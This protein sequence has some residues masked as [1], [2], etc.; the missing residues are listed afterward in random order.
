[1]LTRRFFAYGAIAAPAIVAASSL[2]PIR[3]AKLILARELT[4]AEIVAL[5]DVRLDEGVGGWSGAWPPTGTM[6]DYGRWRP[7]KYDGNSPF[8]HSLHPKGD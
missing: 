6:S 3:A 1:M 4:D 2:M 8:V 7:C 5:L